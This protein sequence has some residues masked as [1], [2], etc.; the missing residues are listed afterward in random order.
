[1]KERLTGAF[2]LVGL[3]VVLV[4]E[5]L[6]GPIHTASRAHGPAASAE[7]PPLRSYT[8]TLTDE[9]HGRSGSLQ[10]Q[11]AS[12]PPTPAA[13]A[14]P[15]GAARLPEPLPA[16][17]PATRPAPAMK[18]SA[19]APTASAAAGT[20]A[21]TSG[22]LVQL[23]SFASRANAERL[24]A[25][26]HGQGFAVSVSRGSAGRRLYRVQVGPVRDHGAAEELAAQL[27]AKGHGGT[28][29]PK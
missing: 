22:Y 6:S 10:I 24:A 27:R 11:A 21:S 17:A 9:P 2:I 5:L 15:G 20:S 28:V 13:A 29:V 18:A 12:T 14:E 8:I 16:P 19:P 25:Q 3:I 4:P 23:G 1:M 26:V 7:G